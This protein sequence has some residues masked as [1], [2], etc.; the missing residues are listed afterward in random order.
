MKST[1]AYY[2]RKLKS[3]QFI[4]P[5]I[6]HLKKIKTLTFAFREV[7]IVVCALLAVL[8]AKVVVAEALATLRFALEARRAVQVA[9]ARLAVGIVVVAKAAR[10]AVGRR[11][12]L[13]AFTSA[14]AFFAVAG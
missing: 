12:L 6:K 9:L 4:I 2:I 1:Q 8:A 13:A 14:G 7:V 11:E 3:R 10:V 5:K